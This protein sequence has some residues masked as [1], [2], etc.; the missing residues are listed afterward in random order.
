[1][2]GSSALWANRSTFEKIEKIGKKIKVFRF[3]AYVFRN[4]SLMTESHSIRPRGTH[5]TRYS[6]RKRWILTL[7]TV[8]RYSGKC[9]KQINE[10]F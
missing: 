10:C 1:M 2:D 6:R 5:K 9:A 8:D 3:I 4:I 7:L